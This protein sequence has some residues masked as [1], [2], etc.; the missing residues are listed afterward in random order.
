MRFKIDFSPRSRKNTGFSFEVE[1]VGPIHAK[2]L[3]RQM[4]MNMGEDCATYKE[5]KVKIIDL[6]WETQS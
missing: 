6:Q 5:P 2:S 3:G 4:L 1:A